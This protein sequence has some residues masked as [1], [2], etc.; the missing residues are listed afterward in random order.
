MTGDAPLWLVLF[1]F[2]AGIVASLLYEGLALVTGLPTISTIIRAAIS[3]FRVGRDAV[4][5]GDARRARRGGRGGEHVILGL[6][7]IALGVCIWLLA[8]PLFP[9]A[10]FFIVAGAVGALALHEEDERERTGRP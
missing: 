8:P 2:A 3:H 9:L 6:I 7:I 4:A 1:V 5:R 10:V